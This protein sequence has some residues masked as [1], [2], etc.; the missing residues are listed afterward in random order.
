[1]RK[2]ALGILMSL[3]A[4][5]PSFASQSY[6]TIEPDYNWEDKYTQ[7]NTDSIIDVAEEFNE[8]QR[9]CAPYASSSYRS[10]SLNYLF[11]YEKG[12]QFV[13]DMELLKYIKGE[14]LSES[15][16]VK[17]WLDKSMPLIVPEGTSKDDALRMIYDWIQSNA[18]YVYSTGVEAEN[19]RN[20]EAKTNDVWKPVHVIQTG[21]ANCVGYSSL[22]RSM[23]NYLIF[24]DN[25]TVR[26]IDES[27]AGPG[28][29]K[30]NML[31][32]SGNGHAWNALAD[33]DGY[34]KYFDLTFDDD[35]NTKK[36][37]HDFYD[38][39]YH[40][41]YKDSKDVEIKYTLIDQKGAE[42]EWQR[43]YYENIEY[44]NLYAS[45][46]TNLVQVVDK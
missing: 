18:H 25:W 36:I 7:P 21:E 33:T 5:F 44:F 8:W 3:L 23:V 30:L 14:L 29:H 38:K 9:R 12:S 31:S 13:N 22:Y 35:D 1:M 24:D 4:A 45:P 17:I 39:T 37:Y 11:Y 42:Y 26:Y 2:L 28:Y 20:F 41:F 34:W 19:L 27:Q 10:R 40:E 46:W 15:A 43:G 32:V 6:F 16:L